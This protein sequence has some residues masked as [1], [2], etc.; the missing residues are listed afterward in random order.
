MDPAVHHTFSTKMQ[1]ESETSEETVGT[2]KVLG[3]EM[4]EELA[5]VAN[6][7]MSD[8]LSPLPSGAEKS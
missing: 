3:K 7:V 8:S 5:P 1:P 6:G 4:R 2:C